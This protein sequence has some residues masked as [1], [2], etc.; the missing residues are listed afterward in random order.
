MAWNPASLDLHASRD[1]GKRSQ[2]TQIYDI[3][4]G[5]IC[6]SMMIMIISNSHR[7][8]NYRSVMWVYDILFATYI[9][10]VSGYL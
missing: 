2:T 3:G 7:K 6:Y 4:Q 1:S 8:L 10:S 9:L 5:D